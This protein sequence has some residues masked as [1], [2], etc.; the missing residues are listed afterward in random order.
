MLVVSIAPLKF[1]F[2]VF[3]GLY[4]ANNWES[5][6]CDMILDTAVQVIEAAKHMFKSK[7]DE[8]KVNLFQ[9]RPIFT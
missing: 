3:A 2:I 4:G 9:F 5:A 6:V 1:L 7:T 8:L